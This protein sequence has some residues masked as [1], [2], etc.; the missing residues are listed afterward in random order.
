MICRI[1][2]QESV[3]AHPSLTGKQLVDSRMSHLYSDEETELHVLPMQ[4]YDFPDYSIGFEI[5]D[6]ILSPEFRFLLALV[7]HLP[8]LFQLFASTFFCI[9][10]I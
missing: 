8:L 5:S 1:G 6:E 10:Q 4:I 3:T 7:F 9:A 2:F